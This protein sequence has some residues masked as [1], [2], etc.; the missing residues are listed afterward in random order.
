MHEALSFSHL[1]IKQKSPRS[2]NP[3]LHCKVYY[4]EWVVNYQLTIVNDQLNARDSH[5]HID[6]LHI[7][8]A[9]ILPASHRV[10]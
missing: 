9:Q 8:S 6:H 7:I 5:L 3:G 1:H 2:M 4:R 10:S